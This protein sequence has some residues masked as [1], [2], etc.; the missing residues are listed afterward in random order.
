MFGSKQPKLVRASASL[1]I[2]C[3]GKAAWTTPIA[4]EI[5]IAEKA[6]DRANKNALRRQPAHASSPLS[7]DGGPQTRTSKSHGWERRQSPV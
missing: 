6:T 1:E 4:H 7:E 3:A 2:F 5:G